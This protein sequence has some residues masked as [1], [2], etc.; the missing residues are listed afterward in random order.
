MEGISLIS[1]LAD[2]VERRMTMQLF[3]GIRIPQTV[4][5]IMNL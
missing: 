2:V 4:M 5:L 3:V 1:L